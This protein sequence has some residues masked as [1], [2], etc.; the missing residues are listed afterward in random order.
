MQK[1]EHEVKSEFIESA[2]PY[3]SGRR[4]LSVYH[5]LKNPSTEMADIYL[6]E[7][8]RR[9]GNFFFRP[10]CENCSN[11]IPL[12]IE[13]EKF[14][15]TKSMRRSLNKNKL[16]RLEIG[17]PEA[18]IEKV[19]LYNHYHFHQ[20]K[21]KKWSFYKFDLETYR[22]YFCE[23][24]AFAKEFR[25]F[26]SSGRLVG[27]GYVDFQTDA[28]SSVY[29]FYHKDWASSSPGFF[30]MLTE[31]EQAKLFGL[32]YYHL[33]YYVKGCLDMNYKLRFQPYELLR[34]KD[35]LWNWSEAVWQ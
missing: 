21:K 6:N 25:Y 9:F 10:N 4:A 11:C 2:C 32:K 18:S 34:G 26:D 22:V 20:M 12:R 30:S 29:F 14:K 19:N 3:F 31:I 17:I 13:I 24:M 33:G 7:G 28:L 27:V 5:T 8:W 1:E 35:E 23:P 16:I 15:P